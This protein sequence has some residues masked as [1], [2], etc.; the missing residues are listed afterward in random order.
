MT[1]INLLPWREQAREERKRNFFAA[2]GA[3]ALLAMVLVMLVHTHYAGKVA[4]QLKRNQMLEHEVRLYDRKI[5]KIKALKKLKQMLTARMEIIASLQASRPQVVHLFDEVVNF[6]PEGL[7]LSK[8][9]RKANN[10]IINGHAE[11]N[12]TC[13][14]YTSPSPRDS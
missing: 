4:H 2:L 11:S 9:E 7:Y 3:S 5:T 8:I 12:T 10:L 13:L 14:L 6:L 1:S